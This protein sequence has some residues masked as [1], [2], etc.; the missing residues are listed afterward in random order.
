MST[1][2]SFLRSFFP[3]LRAAYSW[4]RTPNIPLTTLPRTS[5]PSRRLTITFFGHRKGRISFAVQET[6]RSHP[7]LLLELATPTSHLVKEMAS[8]MVRILLES[9]QGKMK[10]TLWEEPVWSMFCNGQRC[11][12]AVARECTAADL[13]LLGAVSA[14]SV[15]AGVMSAALAL[16]SPEDV[17]EAATAMAPVTAP[18]TA[19]ACLTRNGSKVGGLGDGEVMYMRARFERV[20]GSKDSEALYMM[21]PDVGGKGQQGTGSAGKKSSNGAPELSIFLLR[22]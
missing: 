6:P 18:V 14:V 21:N 10:R 11:G 17:G 22:V 20:V 5:S 16:P 1:A 3:S 12:Y 4:L 19:P 13:K 8:G 7:L 15:G 9:E 2:S